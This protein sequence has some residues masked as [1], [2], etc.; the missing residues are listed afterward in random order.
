MEREN[1]KL[2]ETLQENVGTKEEADA[3]IQELLDLL[4][5]VSP[6]EPFCA[7]SLMACQVYEKWKQLPWDDVEIWGVQTRDGIQQVQPA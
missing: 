2:Q 6:T 1:Y 5:E 7:A 3:Q 4:T